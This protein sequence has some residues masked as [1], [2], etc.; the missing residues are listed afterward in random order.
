[1][2][3]LHPTT[4]FKKDY[5]RLKSRDLNMQLLEQVIRALLKEEPLDPKHLDH[6]LSGA[7]KNYRECH[8]QN[9]WLL[10]YRIEKEKLILVA[11]RTGTHADFGW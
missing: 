1:M 9:D 3:T 8:I 6:P 10:I 4:K 5:K 7:W 11:A 2:L